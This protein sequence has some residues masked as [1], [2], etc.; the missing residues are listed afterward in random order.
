LVRF[1]RVRETAEVTAA[2]L[3]R[4]EKEGAALRSSLSAVQANLERF[5]G[6]QGPATVLYLSAPER[7]ARESAVGIALKPGQ[8]VLPILMEFR[9][10]SAPEADAADLVNVSLFRDGDP[11]PLWAHTARISDLWQR[12]T[13]T[14]SFLLPAALCT[15]GQYRIE[16]HREVTGVL[17]LL[18]RFQVVESTP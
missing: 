10:T 15:V 8:P 14:L 17:L 5:S 11:R 16:I 1:P 6:W 12:E 18:S 2:E 4:R 7:G 3:G 9:P 13:G